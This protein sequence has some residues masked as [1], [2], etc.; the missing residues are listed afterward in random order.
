MEKI[1]LWVILAPVRYVPVITFGAVYAVRPRYDTDFEIVII[2][3][4]FLP[5]CTN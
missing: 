1:I 5:N 3:L 2:A 4:L